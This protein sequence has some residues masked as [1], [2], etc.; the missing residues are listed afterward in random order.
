MGKRAAVRGRSLSASHACCVGCLL[1][2]ILKACDAA[3]TG[4][5]CQCY[6]VA[7]GHCLCILIM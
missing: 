5:A 2:G 1:T 6:E 3:K 7:Q 4:V